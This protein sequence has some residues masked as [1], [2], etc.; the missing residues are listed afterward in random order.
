MP[1]FEYRG[2]DRTG[3]N[4][5]GT[6]DA[7]LSLVLMGY[8]PPEGTPNYVAEFWSK[9]FNGGSDKP[10]LRIWYS[11]V[12][13]IGDDAPEA[14]RFAL[15]QNIPNPFNPDTRVSFTIPNGSS[16]GHVTLK[17]YDVSGRLV[18]TLVDEPRGVGLH[19]VEWNARDNH[20]STVASGVYFYRLQ[21]NGNI[22]SKKMVL[23]R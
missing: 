12:T 4:V 7:T 16:A 11:T 6:I 22:E 5:K 8:N 2:L 17:I 23:L 19:T 15:S 20:G 9:E 21:W 14:D 13:G 3:K 10:I 1:I 18:R